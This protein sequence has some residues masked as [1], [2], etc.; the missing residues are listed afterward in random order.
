MPLLVG[1]DAFKIVLM[2]VSGL[3]NG[4]EDRYWWQKRMVWGEWGEAI[5]LGQEGWGVH[6]MVGK[7]IAGDDGWDDMNVGVIEEKGWI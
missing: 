4:V 7:G 6:I 3:A 5:R 1:S 2:V